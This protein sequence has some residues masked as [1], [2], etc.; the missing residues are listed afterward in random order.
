MNNTRKR[1]RYLI[2]LAVIAAF[3]NCVVAFIISSNGDFL[4]NLKTQIVG[5]EILQLANEQRTIYRAESL[6]LNEE[7]MQAAQMKADDMAEKGYFSHTDP[8]GR[9]F[10]HWLNEA[11]YKY[12]YAAENLA[13][14]FLKS[15]SIIKAWMKSPSHRASMLSEKYSEAGVGIALGS[16]KENPS[17]FVVLLM[18]EPDVPLKVQKLFNLGPGVSKWQ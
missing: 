1:T 16:Y 3:L 11:G 2:F 13:V 15:G 8:E 6:V 7:L 10:S 18:A 12:T 4:N 5:E 17:F 14:K 9:K